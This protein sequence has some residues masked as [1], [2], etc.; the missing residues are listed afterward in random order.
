MPMIQVSTVR[1]SNIPAGME[2][3]FSRVNDADK[4]NIPVSQRVLSILI[5]ELEVA[6]G[7]SSKFQSL[8]LDSL[9]RL[10]RERLGVLRKSGYVC[11]TE[12]HSS[13]FT[14]D[15]LLE[16][17]AREVE[18]TRLSG[19]SIEAAAKLLGFVDGLLE[20]HRAPAMEVLKAAWHATSRA[21]IKEKQA[22][23]LSA[24]LAEFLARQPGDENE[25]ELSILDRVC[26]RLAEH[27]EA[28]R[29]E[30][31]AFETESGF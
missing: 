17:Y 29:I 30:R 15:G 21:K 1:P 20:E 27:A 4:K 6:A 28:K 19:E 10:A 12:V 18:S 25:K 11:P 16:F 5:P 7:V 8:L 14:V 26:Q 23:T 22:A 9:R 31:E 2:E 24:K 3:V 13:L